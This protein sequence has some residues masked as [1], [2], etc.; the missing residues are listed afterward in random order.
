MPFKNSQHLEPHRGSR[1]GLCG[2]T[3]LAGDFIYLDRRAFHEISNEKPENYHHAL[4]QI[5]EHKPW[6]YV[7]ADRY[8]QLNTKGHQIVANDPRTAFISL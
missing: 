5:L 6:G 7:D 4:R 1:P 3:A 8:H 2:N